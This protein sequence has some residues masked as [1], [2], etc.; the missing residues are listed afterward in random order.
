M[1]DCHV[2]S[3]G[4]PSNRG[5]RMSRMFLLVLAAITLVP[6]VSSDAQTL[7]SALTKA[8]R[9]RALGPD[10]GG[11]SIA[12]SG[13]KGRRNE[14]YFG[15]VGG[16]LWK[17]MD[18]GDTWAPVTDGQIRSASVGA[19]AV[20]ETNPDVVFIGMGETCIRGNV[21]SGDG[22][23]KSSDGGKTWTHMGL[24]S[25]ENISKIRIHPTN[26][27]II[28]VAAFGKHSA[29]NADR[30][31]FKTTDGGKT[32]RKVLYRNEMTGA[33]DLSVDRNDPNVL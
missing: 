19:V 8:M 10:R 13:V 30:G 12:A 25:S 23:Y 26:P 17:T 24:A 27:D 14:A 32:W 6:P 7:D 22:V 18:G 3:D 33:I 31:V 1:G 9:W 29:P 15:A 5:S 20:S 11:R 16:G 4:L 2:M 21:M 28:W